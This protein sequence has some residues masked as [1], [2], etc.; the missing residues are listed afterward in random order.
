MCMVISLLQILAMFIMNIQNQYTVSQYILYMTENKKN[1]NRPTFT[2][3]LIQPLLPFSHCIC[4][5]Y[6]CGDEV[7][8]SA[9][10]MNKSDKRLCSFSSLLQ[11]VAQ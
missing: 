7:L 5:F 4:N 11:E 6:W 9:A 10:G 8:V 2:I 1:C 3:F